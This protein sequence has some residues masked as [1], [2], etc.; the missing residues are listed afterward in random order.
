MQDKEQLQRIYRPAIALAQATMRHSVARIALTTA[1]A[2]H[3]ICGT[4]FRTGYCGMKLDDF[5]LYRL[6]VSGRGKARNGRETNTLPGFF[7]LK[8]GVFLPISQP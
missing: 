7:I 2:P 4:A 6:K 5:A 1:E 3:T 8:D